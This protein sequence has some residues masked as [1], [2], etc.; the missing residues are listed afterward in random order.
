MMVSAAMAILLRMA[1]SAEASKEALFKDQCVSICSKGRPNGAFRFNQKLN[2]PSAGPFS[3]DGF[4]GNPDFQNFMNEESTVQC[5]VQALREAK[6]VS[7]KLFLLF[8]E[9]LGGK[10]ACWRALH[11]LQQKAARERRRLIDPIGFRKGGAATIKDISE[12]HVKKAVAAGKRITGLH[13][14]KVT[15]VVPQAFQEFL[16]VLGLS[17]DLATTPWV[18]QLSYA[19]LANP[20]VMPCFLPNLVAIVKGDPHLKL[21]STEI[22][23]AGILYTVA[24]NSGDEWA[25]LESDHQL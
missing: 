11:T 19:L 22:A 12:R 2:L 21:K 13:S 1:A 14:S 20:R 18:S 3:F 25:T 6:E 23:A 16:G 9:V 24:V 7:Q 15:T 4:N 17:A 5:R 10:G 8:D